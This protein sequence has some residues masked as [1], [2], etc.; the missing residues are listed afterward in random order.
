M[1]LLKQKR[2]GFII[3]YQLNM[4]FG[5]I[6]GNRKLKLNYLSDKHSRDRC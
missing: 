2:Q 3:S 4:I 5:K 6:W 1:S